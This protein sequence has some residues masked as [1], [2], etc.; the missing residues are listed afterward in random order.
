MCRWAV[1]TKMGSP[2]KGWGFPSVLST[3]GR[4]GESAKERIV[5]DGGEMNATKAQYLAVE[6]E[7]Q[8]VLKPVPSTRIQDM[9]VPLMLLHAKAR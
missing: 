3:G 4:E 5:H 6:I 2:A 8:R 7:A 1:K 9:H